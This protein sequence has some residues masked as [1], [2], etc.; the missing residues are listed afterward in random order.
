M[1][2]KE[3]SR[4]VSL[5]K[6]CIGKLS[7]F[8]VAGQELHQFLSLRKASILNEKKTFRDTIKSLNNLF[9]R[10]IFLSYFLTSG[11]IMF[12]EKVFLWTIQVS[13]NGK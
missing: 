5:T 3:F 2:V 9:P 10:F 13:D 6:C 12:P 7:T 4:E 11:Y 8:C 1:T